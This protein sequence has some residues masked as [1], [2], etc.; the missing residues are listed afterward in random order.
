MRELDRLR[1]RRVPRAELER[2]KRYVVGQ[3]TMGLERSMSRMVWVGE[4]LLLSG[5][6]PD[7]ARVMRRIEALTA[8]DVQR[9]ARMVFR[10][11]RMGLAYIGPPQD[12]ARLARS[13]EL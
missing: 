6:V 2:A 9:V 7:A 1:A 5:R 13:I 8:D 3:F 11:Q 10:P 4:N 12:E